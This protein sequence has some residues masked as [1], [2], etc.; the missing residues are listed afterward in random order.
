MHAKNNS[1]SSEIE[2]CPWQGVRHSTTRSKIVC[3]PHLLPDHHGSVFT[4]HKR[5]YSI[6]SFIVP[7]LSD[8][9][10]HPG[11]DGNLP[12][13]FPI[14]YGILLIVHSD[15]VLTIFSM[16]IQL[17]LG[18]QMP[19]IVRTCFQLTGQF[20]VIFAAL[21]EVV[22]E[23]TGSYLVIF[24][25]GTLKK[26]FRIHISPIIKFLQGFVPS[27]RGSVQRSSA[28]PKCNCIHFTIK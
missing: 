25:V 5:N 10:V 2:A 1:C 22:R 3:G 19:G 24:I 21:Q 27:S 11:A 15:A 26:F 7:V 28:G 9:R 4:P 14:C 8:I 6:V 18:N 16:V 23:T 13:T 17:M 12:C 20:G